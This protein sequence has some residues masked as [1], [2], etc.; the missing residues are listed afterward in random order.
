MGSV[1]EMY[2]GA[3][4]EIGSDVVM[5][6]DKVLENNKGLFK[7]VFLVGVNDQDELVL[8]GSHSIQEMYIH[9]GISM[10]ELE[11]RVTGKK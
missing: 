10:R 5:D 3:L 8:A 2:P 7:K 1:V 6:P 9:L 11:D 4:D